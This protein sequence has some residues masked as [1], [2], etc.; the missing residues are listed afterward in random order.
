[1]SE[2]LEKIIVRIEAAEQA[3]VDLLY[4]VPSSDGKGR[5]IVRD[6]LSSMSNLRQWC[7]IKGE[8]E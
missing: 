4:Q 6:A 2:K 3:L 1:M 8:T 7:K 5:D